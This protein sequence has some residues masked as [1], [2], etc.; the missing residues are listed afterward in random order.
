M[1]D[2]DRPCQD[3]PLRPVCYPAPP[4]GWPGGPRRRRLEG[5]TVLVRPGDR[6][7]ALFVVRGGSV[8]ES[9]S[10]EP[11]GPGDVVGVQALA[12]GRHARRLVSPGP[13]LVCEV[14][15]G[16]LER[17]LCHRPGTAMTLTRLLSA[18]LARRGH[19]LTG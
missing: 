9:G 16:W 8:L 10:C 5:G 19:P 11:Q 18:A 7:S 6:A 12:G 2:R 14:P 4:A 1:D 15:G 17:R 13:A 3:C